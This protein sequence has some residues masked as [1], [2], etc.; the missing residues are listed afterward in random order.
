MA[1]VC[2][3]C[4]QPVVP[5]NECICDDEDG[6]LGFGDDGEDEEAA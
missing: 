5:V 6:P 2:A 4:R 3:E 1:R